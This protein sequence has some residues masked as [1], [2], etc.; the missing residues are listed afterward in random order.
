MANARCQAV[1]TTF[2]STQAFLELRGCIHRDYL[3]HCL[4]FAHVARYLQLRKRHNTAHMLDVGC[5]REVPLAC[6]MYTNMLTH[7]T[8][9]YTGVDYGPVPWPHLIKQGSSRFHVTLLEKTDFA[10]APLP[11]AQYD[12]VTMFEVAEHVEP[13]HSFRLLQRIR[14]VLAPD[15]VAFISTPC[16]DPHVGAA[17][18]HV[19][20]MGR[21]TLRQLFGAAGLRVGQVRGTFASQRDYE[22]LL[23]ERYPGLKD[24]FEELADYYHP[25]VVACIFAPLFPDVAR[26]CIWKLGPGEV[27]VPTADRAAWLAPENSSSALWPAH[28]AQIYDEVTRAAVR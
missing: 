20:E 12:L 4:R 9:S 21:E 23:D 6:L 3:A 22:H 15:G 16:Y 19:N 26:N 24:V 18:N 27:T 1:D 17:N 8:G 7:T 2:L 14:Q 25:C 10:T 5:G 11:R 13:L 28:A